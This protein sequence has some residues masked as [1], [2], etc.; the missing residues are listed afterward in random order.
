[1]KTRIHLRKAK[2][3]LLLIFTFIVNES[4]SQQP[5]ISGIITD[6]KGNPLPGVSILGNKIATASD[7]D[8]KFNLKSSAVVN[9]D[10]LEF[11]YLGFVSQKVTYNSN[12]SLK[13]ILEEDINKLSEVVVTALNIKRDQKSLGYATQTISSE[14]LNDSRSNNWA[15]ALSGKVAG[16]SL[17]S[18]GSG[19]LNSTRIVLRGVNSLN[20]DGNQALI[21]IDG[22]PVGGGLVS[23]GVNNAYSAGSGNDIPVD[24]GN[25]IADLNPD[26]I[27]SITV[28]KGSGAAALYGSRA[29]NGALMI[30]TKSGARK[31]KGLGITINSNTSLND[32]LKWPDFQHE[33]GQGTGTAIR[34]ASELY[35][36]YGASADG[37]STS[38]TSSAFGP[39]F[40]G[41]S[42]FQ[43]DPIL[44]GQSAE[45]R[46][47]VPY[48]DNVKGFWQTGSTITNSVALE[49]GN[50][51]GSA[52]ASITQ[53]KNQ[54]IMPNTGFDRLTA[55][56][57]LN[58]AVSD[59]LK[60]VSKINYTNKSSDNL[61]G[62]GYN[63]QS[64]SY[65]MIFQNPNVDLNWYKDKWKTG[66]V[67]IDQIHPFSQ[68]IDNPFLIA[69]DMINSVNNYK[70]VG[71]IAATYEITPKLSFLIR[72]GLDMTTEDRA[73]ERPYGTA[74]YQ[75]GYFKQQNLFY[76]EMNTDALLTYKT[77]IGSSF[78]LNTSAGGNLLNRRTTATNGSTIGLIIPGEFKL[79][80]GIS[81]P[82]L[83]TDYQN[84]KV[85]SVYGLAALS[86]KEVVFLDITGRND[87][88][89]TLSRENRS[90]F[91]PSVNTSFILS[92]IF[93]LP[94]QISFAKLRLSASQVGN[95]TDPYLTGKY[96]GQSLFAGSAS[97]PTTL[98]NTDFKPE[99]T[100]SYEAG[101]N[102]SL[103]K[104]RLS[105]DLSYYSNI[106]INQILR[107]P[108]DYSTG[109]NSAVLNAGKVRNRGVEASIT[110]IPVNTKFFKWNTTINWSKNQNRVL[111]LADGIGDRQ[112]IGYGGNATLQARV[113]GTTG[114]I[115]GFGFVRS[116]D[117][118]IVYNANGTTA[119]G[120]EIQYIGNAYADWRGGFSNEFSYKNFRF[121]FL[122]DGQYGG[123]VYSQTHHK[124]SE[125]GKLKH[126]LPGRE[127]GFVIG[128]G[129]VLNADNTYS[130][131]TTKISPASYYGDFYRR[132][133]VESNSF[134]AS[135][136]KLREV[137]F[138]YSLPK[139]ISSKIKLNQVT[140][141]LYGRDLAMITSFPMF[142]PETA[143]L[144]GSTLLPGI[145]M[146]Q[147]PSQRTFGLNLTIKL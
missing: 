118:Q 131:N 126:T 70:T 7:V 20:P 111:E 97:S 38:G 59:K 73:T 139:A 66:L 17:L 90:F 141:G 21:V 103:F 18:S 92:D 1:M 81:S 42:Y 144:N 100:T 85:N 39:K 67:N 129:V 114:D 64:I 143:A 51:K 101:L 116:P 36:S 145:E 49:G 119:R 11:R 46:P 47:W 109:F 146:G 65:F 79:S 55:A 93:K 6:N 28:L 12:K 147:L 107:V 91:Y 53:T 76:Y 108:L 40:N 130:P 96:Y 74:N 33:Y 30:T 4:F 68:F 72:S 124:M 86:Y 135:F 88:S 128:Q 19:P 5:V 35:Y 106:T 3:I 83:T 10:V 58:Y 133:N 99:T 15:S 102:Y 75:R 41:Q 69:E 117:G 110:A 56:V 57:S 50:E 34:P 32:V 24:F 115:Y 127:E 9:G 44:Q 98:Y 54:W 134:D 105:M 140:V 27:E 84:K 104:G 137:R 125:Q 63:N 52:R 78:K 120:P 25:G 37:A 45:R 122:I 8:G 87:W 61:P 23:S 121:N 60:L 31:G 62:T 136:V 16:L 13:I 142:D 94:T 43:Y 26:D 95:D 48:E 80:N 132:A 29:Q 82:V 77:D 113:G 71:N 22:I 2:F 123:I 89:S 112:D 138:E 14:Q